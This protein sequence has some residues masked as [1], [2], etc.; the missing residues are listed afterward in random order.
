[1]K[2]D[3]NASMRL[4]PSGEGFRPMG[5]RQLFISENC[6]S[7]LSLRG[8][9]SRNKR[10]SGRIGGA[11]HADHCISNIG[12]YQSLGRARKQ[13]LSVSC[14]SSPG[15]TSSDEPSMVGNKR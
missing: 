7:K 11:C 6:H 8:N 15:A 3:C 12:R 5:N 9:L 10:F 2:V 13:K 14:S 4:Y 1:M